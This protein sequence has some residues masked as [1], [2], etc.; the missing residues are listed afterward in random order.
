M[1]QCI[2][3]IPGGALQELSHTH[4][5]SARKTKE[6][7]TRSLVRRACPRYVRRC[8]RVIKGKRGNTGSDAWRPAPCTWNRPTGYSG[9]PKTTPDTSEGNCSR[10][11]RK[12]ACRTTARPGYSGWAFETITRL[13]TVQ[14]A[15]SKG[16][17]PLVRS[18]A[19]E[20]VDWSV[21]TT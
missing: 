9:P 12:T 19:L 14:N 21:H 13:S 8:K 11:A 17:L 18:Q 7:S 15:S 4:T 5:G 6:D 1:G 10:S 16:L 3:A 2:R 20:L